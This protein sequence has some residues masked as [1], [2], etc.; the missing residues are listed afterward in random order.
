MKLWALFRFELA[1]QVRRPWIWLIFTALVVFAFLFTRDGALAEVQYADFLLNA[2]F[3]IAG[4]TVFGCV[5]WLLAAAAIAGEAAARDV[6]L[7][8]H[9]LVYTVPVSKA[10]YLGGRF[11][12]AFVLNALILLAVPAGNLLAVYSPGVHPDV[13]GPFRPAAYLTAYAFIALPNAFVATSIQ[14]ALAARSGRPTA[15][16][17][18]SL[19]LFFMGFFVAAFLLFRRGLGTLLDPIGIRF[20][21]E[22]LARS[23]TTTEK[24]WRLLELG[25]TVLRN[26]LLWLAIG[27]GTFATTHVCFRFAHRTESTWWRRRTRYSGAHSPT[28]A[29]IGVTASTPY[30][31]PQVSLTFGFASDARQM[32][33]IAWTSFRTIAKSWAG[34]GLLVGVPLVTVLVVLDQMAATGV[35]LTPTTPLVLQELTA[36]LSAE[37][38]RWVIVPLCIVFFAGELV[39]RERDAGMDEITDAMA[40]REW[41]LFLG[42]FLGLS[43]VL[44]VFMALLA[45][46]GMLAQA[47]LGHQDFEI[48]LYLKVL[49][50]LQLPEY[51]LFA[52]LA[53]FVHVLVD[54]KYIA[55][56]AAIGAYVFIALASMFGVEHSLLIFGAGPSW[57][58]TEMSGFGPSLGPW[59]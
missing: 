28:P 45:I 29:R 50:G 13:V 58:Y 17:L 59:L 24:S 18:G 1:Y 4:A 36:P 51:L 32:L 57:S 33:A 6:A 10:E 44:V 22:D 55:H 42:K 15:G 16:Y 34:L 27:L 54:Q 43:L 52:M 5:V 31:V 21:V 12:A 40:V 53:F 35:P 48:G 23:W 14:F 20:I 30:F 47:V 37:L 7:G 2:P 19:L 56:L 41:V 39:W 9:P 46:A 11:L 26:R 3:M 38:S 25:G 49:L 8:M